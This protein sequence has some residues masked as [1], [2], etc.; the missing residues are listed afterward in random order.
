MTKKPGKYTAAVEILTKIFS[1]KDKREYKD[2]VCTVA[3]AHRDNNFFDPI[4]PLGINVFKKLFPVMEK[5]GILTKV[6]KGYIFNDRLKL[7]QSIKILDTDTDEE[8]RN[9]KK[10][11]KENLSIKIEILA[12]IISGYIDDG[13]DLNS[14]EARQ[15]KQ[16]IERMDFVSTSKILKTFAGIVCHYDSHTTQGNIL[17]K[18]L[19][20]SELNTPCNIKAKINDSILKINDVLIK[21]I[22]I[23]DNEV[24]IIT[25][26]I[27]LPLSSLSDIKNI[28]NYEDEK[29]LI[30]DV[31]NTISIC[32][33]HK[34][35]EE[36]T[37]K[38]KSI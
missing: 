30:D 28:Y 2:K 23:G 8:K 17:S 32:T 6:S 21:E 22:I 11:R 25:S 1:E 16:V 19:L 37:D 10:E 12:G 34:E 31:K 38:L 36:F 24:E 18:L 7:K 15:V 14:P 3:Q 35:L 13:L 20:F 4:E 5:I 27:P 26:A 29:V 9:K 33:E